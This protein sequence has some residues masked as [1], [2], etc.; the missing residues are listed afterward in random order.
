MRQTLC[1]S[2]S[3]GKYKITLKCKVT[4]QQTNENVFALDSF[5][6]DTSVSDLQ[7]REQC[8]FISLWR[9]FT[10]IQH[11]RELLHNNVRMASIPNHCAA[12]SAGRCSSSS[13][14]KKH[15]NIPE[16][17]PVVESEDSDPQWSPVSSRGSSAPG[18]TLC[19]LFD[20]LLPRLSPLSCV[21]WNV[22]NGGNLP[23]ACRCL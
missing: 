23:V 12:Q 16:I 17:F 1:V 19:L 4:L 22:W 6:P 15:T 11:S 10:Q 21:Q 18:L 8:S 9:D 20:L 2:R 7:S 3:A 5:K 13:T 14:R